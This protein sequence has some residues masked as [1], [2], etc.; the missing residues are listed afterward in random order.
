MFTVLVSKNCYTENDHTLFGPFQIQRRHL[1]MQGY[2]VIEILERDFYSM[3]VA[4]KK[5]KQILLK[6]LIMREVVNKEY[7]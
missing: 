4:T 5:D 3:A 6:K 2:Y 7:R 1:E